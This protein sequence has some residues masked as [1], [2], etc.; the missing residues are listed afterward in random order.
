[1]VAAIFEQG[2]TLD[3]FLGDGIMAYFGAPAAQPDHADRAVRCAQAM[4]TT[5]AE[6]NAERGLAGLP[7]L[8]MGIGLHPASS[9][10]VTSVRRSAA[11][12]RSSATR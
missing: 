9:P 6:L 3:K 4:Q 12:T 7:M 1:M 8:R 2:G 11:S 5:L 10:S